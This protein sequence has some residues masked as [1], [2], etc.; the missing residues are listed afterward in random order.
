MGRLTMGPFRRAAQISRVIWSTPKNK[1]K[2]KKKKHSYL[3]KLQDCADNNQPWA[4]A[5][6]AKSRKFLD[7][8]KTLVKNSNLKHYYK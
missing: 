1:Q 4:E 3:P 5:I 2:V 8:C 7:I 6:K